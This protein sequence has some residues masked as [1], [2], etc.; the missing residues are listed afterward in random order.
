[1]IKKFT[2]LLFAIIWHAHSIVYLVQFKLRFRNQKVRLL[3]KG[4]GEMFKLIIHFSLEKSYLI[5]K[6]NLFTEFWLRFAG[7]HKLAL[8]Q[9]KHKNFNDK[10]DVLQ[11]IL[12]S[13]LRNFTLLKAI[14]RK[15]KEYTQVYK[16]DAIDI[17]EGE[18]NLIDNALSKMLFEFKRNGLESYDHN[19][20]N[21]LQI[22]DQ[23]YI[24]DLDSFE[25]TQ[26][27]Q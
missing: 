14:D 6:D 22:G 4:S 24:V 23:I 12:D 26:S 27:R 19:S 5:K 18:S 8:N 11:L 7:K 13:D 1:M 17:G 21:F 16:E 25:F 3:N 20:K 15:R 10:A 9:S 2:K